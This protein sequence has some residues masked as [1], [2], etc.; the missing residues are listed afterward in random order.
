MIRMQARSCRP[1]LLRRGVA[2]G[3]FLLRLQQRGVEKVLAGQCRPVRLHAL[4]LLR[5]RPAW[6]ALARMGPAC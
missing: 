6:V 4:Q 5:L 1:R 3:P 2:D